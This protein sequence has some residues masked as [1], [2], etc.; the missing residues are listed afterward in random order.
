MSRFSQSIIN[1]IIDN[2]VHSEIEQ[3]YFFLINY[4]PSFKEAFHLNQL[5]LSHESII[6][7]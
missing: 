2:Q 6:Y 1:I 4:L 5:K 7:S 3:E